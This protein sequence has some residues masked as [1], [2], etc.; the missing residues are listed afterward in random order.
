VERP[1]RPAGEFLR[2][3]IPL[4]WLGLAARLPGKALAVAL[5]IWFESGRKKNRRTVTL[6]RAILDR[7]GVNRYAAYRALQDLEGAGLVT[8]KRQQGKNS[9]VTLQEPAQSSEDG[10]RLQSRTP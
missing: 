10:Q 4:E 5:A 6:T 9:V 3:P 1:P 7:F 2:G 8:V